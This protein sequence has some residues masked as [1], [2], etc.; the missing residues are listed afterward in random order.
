MTT[1]AIAARLVE[2][3]RSGDW[4]T[5]QHELYA[6]DAVSIE[7]VASPEFDKETKGLQAILEKGRKFEAMISESNGNT[8]SEHLITQNAIAF[9]LEMDVTMKGRERTKWAELCVYE[10]KDGK[11]VL[12]QFFM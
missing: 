8:V 4:E 6:Q 1:A 12:E 10:V 5:A 2:L 9:K 7:P 3:C 11:I